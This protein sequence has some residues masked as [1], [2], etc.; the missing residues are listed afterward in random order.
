MSEESVVATRDGRI[1]RILLNR[2]KVLNAL[3][4]EMI[5]AISSAL[6]AWR[7]DPYVHAVVIEAAGERAFCAGGD[8]RVDTQ[9]C[10]GR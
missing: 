1:G 2:P 5:R 3:D 4:L 8:I 10:D 6:E 7:D 9:S